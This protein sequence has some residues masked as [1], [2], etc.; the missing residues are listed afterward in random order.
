ML[1]AHMRRSWLSL[2]KS[3]QFQ[4]LVDDSYICT[5]QIIQAL[6][7]HG[8]AAPVVRALLVPG[9]DKQFDAP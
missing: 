7:L 6:D 9:R 4:H 3:S 8:K 1:Y 2:S 5:P